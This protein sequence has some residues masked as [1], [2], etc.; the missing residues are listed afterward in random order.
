MLEAQ[1]LTNQMQLYYAS[2][3]HELY[4]MVRQFNHDPQQF[5]YQ[6]LINQLNTITS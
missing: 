3:R 6:L 1:N 4:A 2:K 5:D